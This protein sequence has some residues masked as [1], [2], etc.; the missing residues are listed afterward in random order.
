MKTKLMVVGV[1]WRCCCAASRWSLM[2]RDQDLKVWVVITAGWPRT[3][4]GIYG[5]RTEPD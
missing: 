2:A 5:S 1:Y 4:H 3:R